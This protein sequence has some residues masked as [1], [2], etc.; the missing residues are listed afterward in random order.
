MRGQVSGSPPMGLADSGGSLV[1]KTPCGIFWQ[2]CSAPPAADFQHGGQAP[3]FAASIMFGG[4]E[5]TPSLTVG[6]L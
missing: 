3:A 1:Q 4:S 2:P 5:G 6:A